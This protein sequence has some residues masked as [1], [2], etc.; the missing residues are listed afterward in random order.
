M[1]DSWSAIAIV[2]T[3]LLLLIG[4]CTSCYYLGKSAGNMEVYENLL[5]ADLIKTGELKE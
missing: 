4:L 3:G 1:K 2:A 5:E